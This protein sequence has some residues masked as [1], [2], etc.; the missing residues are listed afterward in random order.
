[1]ETIPC[2]KCNATHAVTALQPPPYPEA[3]KALLKD[4]RVWAIAFGTTLV[5]GM[6][7]GGLGV[8]QAYVGA[9]SGAIIGVTMWFRM[10]QLRRCPGCGATFAVPGATA[11]SS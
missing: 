2:P 1:M 10:R 7:S 8:G 4:W 11:K 9:V 3:A 6:L 5:L